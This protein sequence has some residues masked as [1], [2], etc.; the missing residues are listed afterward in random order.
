M[1]DVGHVPVEG[2]FLGCD[3]KEI[4]EE[5]TEGF[6]RP[7]GPQTQRIINC[8]FQDGWGVEGETDTAPIAGSEMRAEL[9]AGGSPKAV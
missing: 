9:S 6:F 4:E 2:F 8:R 3:F 1:A 7:R 5:K